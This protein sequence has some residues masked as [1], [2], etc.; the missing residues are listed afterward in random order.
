MRPTRLLVFSNENVLHPTTPRSIQE[1]Q[2]G[3]NSRIYLS[4]RPRAAA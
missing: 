2:V 1:K 3:V 4:M